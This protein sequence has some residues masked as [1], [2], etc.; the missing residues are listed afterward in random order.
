M[1]TAT[2][3][4]G[5]TSNYDY[6]DAGRLTGLQHLKGAAGLASYTYQ[7]DDNGN[8]IR[9][10]EDVHQP[11]APP[12]ATTTSTS[13]LTPTE[14]ST[15]TLTPTETLTGTP[16]ST[17][18]PLSAGHPPILHPKNGGIEGGLVSYSIKPLAQA[19]VTRTRTLTPTITRTPTR[20]ATRTLT[21]TITRTPTRTLSPTVTLTRTI[22]PT[23]TRT[24]TRTITPTSTRTS[25]RTP[26]RTK[27]STPTPSET[28]T[29]T[30]TPTAVFLPPGEGSGLAGEYF[31]NFDLDGAPLFVRLDP[32]VNF[33]LG[34]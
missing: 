13:T 12:T 26:T 18:T 32:Q 25:T 31:N 8:R 27:T 3:P 6:D 11:L 24:I 7:Y 2:L 10:I 5:V 30:E 28:P 23:I 19:T 15:Q 29:P 34:R 20:T 9:A 16:T 17:Q 1:R 4:N 33:Q 22:T 21:P 14:T